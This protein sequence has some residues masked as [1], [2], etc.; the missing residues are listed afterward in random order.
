MNPL[1]IDKTRV[2]ITKRR[3]EFLKQHR[4][5]KTNLH[6]PMWIFLIIF[7]IFFV[8]CRVKPSDI[9]GL[10]KKNQKI[11]IENIDIQIQRKKNVENTPN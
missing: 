4:K 11:C 7:F 10:K 3:K 1:G 5:R 9:I 6:G 2:S 8:Y